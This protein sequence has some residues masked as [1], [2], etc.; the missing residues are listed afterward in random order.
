MTHNPRTTFRALLSLVLA[1]LV[2]PAANPLLAAPDPPPDF[3]LTG[4]SGGGEDLFGWS[5]AAAGDV[6]GDS[7]PDLIVGAPSCDE[8]AGFA[9]RAYLFYGP[10]TGD[11]VAADAD[12]IISAQN[13]GD[14]LGIS[15]ASAGDTDNDGKDDIL[16]GA[17]SNDA[18]GIQAGQAY[19][20]RGPVNG[21]L[22]PNQ[23]TAVITGS[24]F[25]ELGIGVASAGDINN[26][27]FGD[28]V[29]GAHQFGDSNGRAYVFFGPVS[30]NRLSA[31]ANAIVTGQ[32][33]NDSVGIALA[34][35]DVDNDGFDDLV[36]GAPHG[37]I[38]F[39]DPGRV[40]LFFGP[41]SGEMNAGAADVIFR[42]EMDNDLFGQ[43]VDT[44]D[45]N[46]DGLADVVVGANQLFNDGAGKAYV[47]LAPFTPGLIFAVNA[48]GK[49]IGEA[50]HDNFGD[51]VAVAGDVNGDGRD[52]MLVGAWDN[53]TVH[54]RGG[55][56][57][58]FFGPVAGQRPALSADLIVSSEEPGDR[59]GKSVNAAGDL[60]GNGRS[61]LIIGAPEF[62][63]GDPGKAF[64]YFDHVITTG[65]D[66]AALPVAAV[67]LSQNV[68]NPFSPSTVIRF[69][70]NAESRATITIYDVNGA[71][72]RRLVDERAP[73]GSHRVAWDGRNEL[74]AP[75]AGGVYFY[76]LE[77]GG[78]VET[79]RMVLTR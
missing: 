61:D 17:R 74:G 64:V 15:V 33:P 53:G 7:F 2:L 40:H 45:M 62:P 79:R 11:L 4:E 22:S 39:L 38:D 54:P 75:V 56:A 19:L 21:S 34:A 69:R 58:L 14:N 70:L 26:D 72:V 1:I 32:F 23:A 50:P 36:L 3:R 77:T 71:V 30:G 57:Y 63:E 35:G 41:I 6:N 55:R 76:R 10:F 68:P 20:F 67:G 43:S 78:R 60:N 73:A 66:D 48:N 46:G 9:G 44:G 65:G 37:P 28:I 13:F 31:S 16:I 25:E 42:G 47:F 24:A 5:V 18:G 49:M 59:V 29:I 51:A 8:V 52:D 12:A 27:G